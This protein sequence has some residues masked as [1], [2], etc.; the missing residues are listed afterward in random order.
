MLDNYVIARLSYMA[1]LPPSLPTATVTMEIMV[2]DTYN[3]R[4]EFDSV[5]GQ[6]TPSNAV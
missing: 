5:A 2:E 6:E 1:R 4:T 3:S